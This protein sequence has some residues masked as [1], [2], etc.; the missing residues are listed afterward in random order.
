MKQIFKKINVVM[1]ALIMISVL[2][3]MNDM[4]VSAATTTGKVPFVVNVNTDVGSRRLK[5]TITDKKTGDYK[6]ID[7]SFSKNGAYKGTITGQT[8]RDYTIKLEYTDM[9][10]KKATTKTFTVTKADLKKGVKKTINITSNKATQGTI[11]VK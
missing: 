8:D 3:G 4:K 2:F 6:W 5:I 10:T 9:L 11:T 1:A 7:M